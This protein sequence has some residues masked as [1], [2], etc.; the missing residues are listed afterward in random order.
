VLSFLGLVLFIIAA[1]DAVCSLLGWS[2][3]AYGWSPVIFGTLGFL[4][5]ALE[6]L[7]RDSSPARAPRADARGRV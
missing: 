3:T 2:L 1:V 6:A 5:I 4:L 7:E